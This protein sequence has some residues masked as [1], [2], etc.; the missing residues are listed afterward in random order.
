MSKLNKNEE[1]QLI[2]IFESAKTRFELMVAENEVLN[3]DNRGILMGV[4]LKRRQYRQAMIETLCAS[5]YFHNSIGGTRP[6]LQTDAT[7]ERLI[8][9]AFNTGLNMIVASDIDVLARYIGLRTDNMAYVND[10]TLGDILVILGT[11]LSQTFG[12]STKYWIFYMFGRMGL[13]KKKADMGMIMLDCIKYLYFSDDGYG[14]LG[15][16]NVTITRKKVGFMNQFE[17]FCRQY[18]FAEFEY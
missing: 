5:L 10:F 6:K 8:T 12:G 7:F 15:V 11:K 3:P 17:I 1:E 16:K 18:Q 2:S 13:L 4:D 9:S 14:V